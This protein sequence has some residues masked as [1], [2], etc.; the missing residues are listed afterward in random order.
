MA[1]NKE[2]QAISEEIDLFSLAAGEGFEIK[3]L[4]LFRVIWCHLVPH[5]NDLSAFGCLLIPCR[6][7]QYPLLK[8]KNKAKLF[9]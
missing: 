7:I 5:V 4:V 2:K 1:W 8:G 9:S 6:V 3:I